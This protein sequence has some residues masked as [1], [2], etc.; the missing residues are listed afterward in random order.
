MDHNIS[1]IPIL[2]EKVY[3]NYSIGIGTFEIK[4]LSDVE[5]LCSRER[6]NK[7][8]SIRCTQ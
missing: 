4:S 5:P 2:I 3:S 6:G 7:K 8:I 1:Q